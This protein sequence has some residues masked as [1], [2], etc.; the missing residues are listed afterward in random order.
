[1][2][3]ASIVGVNHHLK[4]TSFGC[5]LLLDETVNSSIWLFDTFLEAMGNGAPKTI[6]ID[7]DEAMEKSC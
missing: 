1:M 6:F 4:N 7:Q 5:A 2:I 3:C